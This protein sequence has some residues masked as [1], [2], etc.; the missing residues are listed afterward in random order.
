MSWRSG[1]FLFTVALGP[2]CDTDP[3]YGGRSSKDWIEALGDPSPVVRTQAA[4]AL[5]M[6]LEIQPNSPHVVDA[7]IRALADSVDGV[8]MAAATALVEEGVRA[9]GAMSGIH[10]AL[11]DTAH[12]TVRAHAALILGSLRSSAG[13]EAV[14]A[15]IE[16]LDDRDARVRA[17][18]TE[19][20]G[21]FGRAAAPALDALR[22]HLSD[23]SATV[24]LRTLES[25]INIEAPHEVVVPALQLSL[26][27]HATDVRVAAAYLLGGLRS[28]AAPAVDALVSTLR[29]RDPRV[30]AAALFA[31]VEVGPRGRKALPAIRRLENDP[32]PRVR[33]EA[34]NAILRLSR[35]E[36][37]MPER[38]RDRR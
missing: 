24:R 7:L 20:L 28:A 29:D 30:R 4:D 33:N 22:S 37:R 8:R 9:E 1:L 35:P 32:D 14:P 12:A 18:A 19:A 5:G 3:G 13:E 10:A 34:K 38:E 25:L 6:V 16:A 36:L 15:L 31:I 2:A 27:D 23:S 17:A 26:S 21:K 11:H